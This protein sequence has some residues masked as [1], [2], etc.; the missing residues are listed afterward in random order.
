MPETTTLKTSVVER[1]LH[2]VTFDTQSAERSTS[3]PST[4]KQLVL[5]D[6]LAQ[7]LR[8]IGLKD[9]ARDEHGYVMATIPATTKKKGVPV[10]G[11]VAHVDT[12]PEVS[13]AGVKPIVHHDWRGQDIVLPDEPSVV[14]RPSEIPALRE[15]VGNDII[16][17]SGTT[18]LG[19]D[20]KAGVAEIVAA[21]EYLMQHPEI[22]H[23]AIRLAFTPDE[24]VGRGTERFDVKK[25]G[26][27]CAYT[28]D[29][30]GRGQL[31]M[32]T[33]SADSMTVT[34]HG[35]NTHPG[36]AKGKL[37]NAIKVAADFVARLPRRELSPETTEG[38]EGFVHPY[39]L[40]GGV[41]SASVRFIVRDFRTPGLREKEQQVEKLAFEAIAAWPGASVTFKVEESY[42]NM[43]EVLE[44]YPLVVE[45]AREAIRRSGLEV[46]ETAVRGGTD[47]SRLSFMGLPTP[48]IFAGEN[49]Y[50]SRLEWVS[51]QDME[52]A[53]EVIANLARVWEERT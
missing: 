29:A 8:D 3:Y 43:R 40:E 49:N 13:G 28:M 6:R 23:G 20:N 5:L 1:F 15:Q 24:E 19:A 7:E 37:V 48:N 35:F 45:H 16:T 51:A 12:S 41:D 47:G 36:Y 22:P 11:F 2:Y 52:K 27:Y 38:R 9:A 21:A 33:F 30:G 50:H 26:A 10:I 14:L 18:L 32:E 42:R 4:S 46:R 31:E 25:F 44:R 39:V 17:A 53:V 34:F